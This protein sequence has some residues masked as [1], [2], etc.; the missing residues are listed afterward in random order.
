MPAPSAACLGWRTW[1]ARR[2]GRCSTITPYSRDDSLKIALAH[3]DNTRLQGDRRRTTFLLAVYPSLLI[4]LTPGYF[5]YLS[6][7]PHGPGQVDIVYGGGLSPDF[8]FSAESQAHFAAVKT[9][10]DRVNVEDRGCTEKV[11]RGLSSA[12]GEPGHLSHLERPNFDFAQYLAA[13]TGGFRRNI[14]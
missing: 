8:A 14:A 12:S 11:Y 10:L 1:C 9:L 13:R 5:W 3:P 2:G 7:H 4:T 6:L